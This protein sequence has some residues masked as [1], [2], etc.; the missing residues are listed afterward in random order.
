M[1]SDVNLRYLYALRQIPQHVFGKIM[2]ARHF[3]PATP[4]LFIATEATL[5]TIT[6]NLR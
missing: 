5:A 3:V 4:T 2:L 6:L 1:L